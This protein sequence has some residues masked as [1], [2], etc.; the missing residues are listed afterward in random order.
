MRVAVY[1]LGCKVNQFESASIMESLIGKGLKAAPFHEQAD[2]YIIN[3]CAVTAKAAYQSRQA[4]RRAIHANSAARVIV[5]GCYVQA[6]IQRLIDTMPCSVCLVGN[7]Q[8]HLIPELA[9]ADLGCLEI[10]AGD[11]ARVQE[12]APFAIKAPFERTRAFVRIQDGCNAFCSYCIVPYTRGRP[13]SLPP[14]LVSDQVLTLA[15]A[16]VKEVVLTGIHIGLYGGDL[17]DNTSLLKLMQGLCEAFSG[18]RFRLSSIEP[19]EVGHE[20]ILWA[21]ATPNF[22][23]HWHIPLQSA[24]AKVLH[25]MNRRYN[26]GLFA[27]TVESIK[28]T[29]PDAA[30]GTDVLAGFP[31]EDEGEFL[32]TLAFLEDLPISYI[33]AFPYSKRPGTLA[34]AMKDAI[35][36]DEKARRVKLL[37]TLGHKKRLVFWTSQLGRTLDCLLE[38]REKEDGLW[39]GLTGN[40]VPVAVKDL[41][42]D[43][44]RNMLMPVRL[45]AIEGA[46][47]V[48]FL[49]TSC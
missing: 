40:Y 24:S 44:Y 35:P 5:T 20:M 1:T 32:K 8:K 22:C 21:S 16:G 29:L 2:I 38:R 39:R 10:Y 25:A 23:R 36:G 9:F 28:T 49:D 14:G 43:G 34:S 17:P 30:I 15:R 42:G 26:P 12:I 19:T 6:D 46:R 47:V 41:G 3:T 11:I 7:D 37:T 48:A 13:R 27:K 31:V 18:I 33:H 4:I 45:S